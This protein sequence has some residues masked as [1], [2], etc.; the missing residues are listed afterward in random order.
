[1]QHDRDFLPWAAP[2][3]LYEA[4]GTPQNLP[5]GHVLS[6]TEASSLFGAAFDHSAVYVVADGGRV[7]C[8][9]DDFTAD[10]NGLNW[11]FSGRPC[12]RGH[13]APRKRRA[14][15]RGSECQSCR[16]QQPSRRKAR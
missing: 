5:R 6:C 16:R 10:E 8:V 7:R 4:D 2:A 1:M 15:P 11:T 14:E 9:V 12:P 13:I 3:T